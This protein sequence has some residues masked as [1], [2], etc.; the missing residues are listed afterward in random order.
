MSKSRVYE[1]QSIIEFAKAEQKR[2]QP[3]AEFPLRDLDV[4]RQANASNMVRHLDNLGNIRRYQRKADEIATRMHGAGRLLDWGA[5][6]G[7]M[8]FLLRRRGIEAVPFDVEENRLE[9]TLLRD[10]DVAY[11]YTSHLTRLPFTTGSF[12]A[13]L[14][15]GTLEHVAYPDR[16]LMEL[17]RVL[18]PGGHLF[19]YNLPNRLSWTE[20]L[21]RRLGSG[22]ERLYR[23]S[24]VISWL[25]RNGVAV[26]SHRAENV[27]PLTL[28]ALRHRSLGLRFTPV[29]EEVDWRLA[30]LQPLA[31]VATNLT[32]IGVRQ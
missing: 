9:R 20:F 11:H 25:Q 10:T 5:L 1:A 32:F 4:I 13:V 15:S 2:L 3:A 14:S 26:V 28:S 16:S 30:N 6:Y 19:I 21:A 23:P 18:R 27:F 17:V 7:Q 22:H 12:D 24:E 8:T 29:L 31:L